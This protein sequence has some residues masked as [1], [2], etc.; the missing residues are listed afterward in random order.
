MSKTGHSCFGRNASDAAVAV[1]I[2]VV[3]VDC[4][5][6][7]AS[8]DADGYNPSLHYGLGAVGKAT[9]LKDSVA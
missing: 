4:F 6:E 8:S 5:L 3:W 1:E 7:S 9:N 2:D